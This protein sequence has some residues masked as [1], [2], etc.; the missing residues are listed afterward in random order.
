MDINA[1]I[2]KFTENG[3]SLTKFATSAGMSRMYLGHI[4]KGRKK[5]PSFETVLGLLIASNGEISIKS[6]RPDL[7]PRS[8]RGSEALELIRKAAA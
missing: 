4:L 1:Y 3:G 2:D 5:N 8:K 6:L 7:F